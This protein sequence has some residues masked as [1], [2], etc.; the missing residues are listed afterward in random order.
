AHR[1]GEDEEFVVACLLHDVGDIL[2]PANHSEVAAAV[3]RP[4]VSERTYWIIRHHGLF[5]AFYYYHHFG[6]DRNERDRFK[7]HEWY[8]DTIDFCENYDQNCFDPDYE[9]EPLEFFEPMLR[10]FFRE[11]KGH[12]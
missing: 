5:Q 8:Q 6:K 12:V 9:S 10:R 7:D 2:A 1:A 4:Y 3:M 11:P